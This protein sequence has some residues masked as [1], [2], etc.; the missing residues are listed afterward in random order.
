MKGPTRQLNMGTDRDSILAR[1]LGSWLLPR[2]PGC[3]KR[4]GHEQTSQG[5][6]ASGIR[7]LSS[8]GA[9]H[10]VSLF[11]TPGS[12]GCLEKSG[13]RLQNLLDLS[14]GTLHPITLIAL[15]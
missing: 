3:G 10:V 6:A 8:G 4:K 5:R 11:T 14:I 7:A 2:A 9:D 1:Q 13:H 12:E 15:C